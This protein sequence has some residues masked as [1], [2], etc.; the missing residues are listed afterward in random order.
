MGQTHRQHKRKS[1]SV[2]KIAHDSL[3]TV[4]P[5]LPLIHQTKLMEQEVPAY[6]QQGSNLQTQM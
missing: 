2:N 1:H 3:G 5:W 4:H 6:F